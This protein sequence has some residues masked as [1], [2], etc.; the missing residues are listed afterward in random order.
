MEMN[1]VADMRKHDDL[2]NE[3]TL[4]E[5]GERLH[6]ASLITGLHELLISPLS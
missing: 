6:R 5:Q 1:G 4:N 2:G 3:G